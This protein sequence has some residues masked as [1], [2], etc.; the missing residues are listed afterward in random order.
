MQNCSLTKWKTVAPLML[1]F[2]VLL[3]ASAFAQS[4]DDRKPA[5][6]ITSAPTDPPGERIAREP[7]KGIVKGVNLQEYRVVVYALG[8]DTWWVQPLAN[9][10]LTM[11]A[12]DGNWRTS[13][14]GGTEFAALL[15]KASFKPEPQLGSRPDAGGEIVAVAYK[16]P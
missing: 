8:G 6:V 4:S 12:D 9:K 14:H 3:S 1:C 13:T 11:I 5:I 15:V 10:P 16:S 2:S 7:I